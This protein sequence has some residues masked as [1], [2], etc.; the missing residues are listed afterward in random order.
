MKQACETL[1][2]QAERRGVLLKLCGGWG[3]SVHCSKTQHIAERSGRVFSD[4]DFAS[5][6]KDRLAVV[7]LLHTNGYREVPGSATVPGLR[8]TT[9]TSL[10]GDIHGDV[11]YDF[12][13]FSHTIDLKG[14]LEVDHPTIPLA[15]LFLQKMQIVRFAE[16]DAIDIQR[17]LLE[18]GFSEDDKD[19]INSQRIVR[20]C[21]RNWGL[22]RTVTVNE[23]LLRE[24]TVGSAILDASEKVVVFSR[25]NDL[26]RLLQTAPK[27]LGWRLRSMIGDRLP[28]YDTVEDA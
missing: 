21:S 1:L 4:L 25:L 26:Q 19:H 5:Y 24:F 7:D 18:H 28:W 22:W 12:L 13:S 14:R 27:T 23:N 17:L 15:E 9:F 8:R 2:E 3:C 11:F 10:A 16:K 6:Q 20:L